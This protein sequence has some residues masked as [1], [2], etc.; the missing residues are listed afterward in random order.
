VFTYLLTSREV[1]D[2]CQPDPL[3]APIVDA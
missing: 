2:A 3:D 1:E